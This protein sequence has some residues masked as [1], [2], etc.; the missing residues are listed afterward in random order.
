MLVAEH[1]S[2]PFREAAKVILKVS[3]NLHASMMPYVLGALRGKEST[4]QGDSTSSE[5]F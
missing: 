1:V 2:P 5:S 4:L 3:Q